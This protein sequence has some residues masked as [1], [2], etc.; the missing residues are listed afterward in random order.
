MFLDFFLSLRKHKLPVGINEYL[1]FLEVLQ[2]EIPEYSIENF[3]FL[4]EREENF[5][6]KK[7]RKRD[8]KRRGKE[9]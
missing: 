6:Q 3:Y 5:H 7:K 9:I 2:K 8:L 4:A 1:A